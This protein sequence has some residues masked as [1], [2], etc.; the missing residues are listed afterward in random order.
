MA[1]NGWNKISTAASTPQAQ[2]R[3]RGVKCL[4]SRGPAA[5]NRRMHTL[6][7]SVT[8]I[9]ALKLSSISL[10]PLLQNPLQSGHVLLGQFCV[11]VQGDHQTGQGAPVQAL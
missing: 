9:S 1:W 10:L 6:P 5:K 7:P 8:D 11:R 2:Y 4:D 3:Q